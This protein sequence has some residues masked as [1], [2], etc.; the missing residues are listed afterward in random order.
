[1]SAA[2][3]KSCRKQSSLCAVCKKL[4]L[5]TRDNPNF[6]APTKRYFLD[7]RVR[8]FCRAFS[9]SAK[10]SSQIGRKCIFIVGRFKF[11]QRS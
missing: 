5:S 11:L 2:A 3:F 7:G 10:D 1:M 4:G 6:T 8:I 9:E